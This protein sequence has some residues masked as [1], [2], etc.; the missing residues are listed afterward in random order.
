VASLISGAGAKAVYKGSGVWSISLDSLINKPLSASDF[1][2]NGA[3]RVADTLLTYTVFPRGKQASMVMT[4][5]VDFISST[6]F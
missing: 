5:P 6:G 3:Q 2:L 1:T 4:L